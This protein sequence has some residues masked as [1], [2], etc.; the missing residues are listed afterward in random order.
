MITLS[1][2]MFIYGLK[3]PYSKMRPASF[4]KTKNI[5]DQKFFITDVQSM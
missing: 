5:L 4:I 2:I 1:D 3:D